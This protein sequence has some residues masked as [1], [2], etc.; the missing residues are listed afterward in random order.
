[1]YICP[2]GISACV[3]SFIVMPCMLTLSKREGPACGVK[4]QTFNPK[5]SSPAEDHHASQP[6]LFNLSLLTFKEQL[7]CISF[8]LLET[9]SKG[10][11]VVESF[12]Q[13]QR[14]IL[15]FTVS[16]KLRNYKGLH[17]SVPSLHIRMYCIVG[18]ETGRVKGQILV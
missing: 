16:N 17:G 4:N 6:P 7:T 12:T 10:L 15:C 3:L 18:V 14:K 11:G 9:K 1:M 8:L 2:Q 5:C 13:N